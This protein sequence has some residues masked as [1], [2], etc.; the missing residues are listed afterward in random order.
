MP[1]LPFP[2]RVNPII[3]VTIRH[4]ISTSFPWP[5][6]VAAA[7]WCAPLLAGCSRSIGSGAAA[8]AV[9]PA[10]APAVDTADAA[11][12]SGMILH[13]AQ[14]VLM[15]SWAPT[16]GASPAVREVCDRIVVSQRDEIGYMGR[17]LRDHGQPVPQVDTMPGP[18]TPP[19]NEAILGGMA[20]MPGMAGGGRGLMPGMLDDAQ[21]ARLDSARGPAFDR[22]FLV[23]MIGH[24]E[25]ALSMVRGLVG[26]PGATQDQEIFE[27][28]AEIGAGQG[29][30]IE[31]MQSLLARLSPAAPAQ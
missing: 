19:A 16:H 26:T 13:H 12:M 21:L 2:G 27:F 5:R 25:G 17:W 22:L 15:A 1:G 30:E 23:D 10:A 14:A 11:F 18:A 3:L 9:S 6:I 20:G 4:F 29:A 28:A 8:A 24:H 7:V 31:R